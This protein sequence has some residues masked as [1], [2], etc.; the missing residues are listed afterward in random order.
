[1]QIK[2]A[3]LRERSTSGSWINFAV[4]AASA[5]TSGNSENSKALAQLTA[6]A[7]MAGYQVD[8]SALAFTENGRLKFY[9]SENLVDYL[10]RSWRPQWTHTITV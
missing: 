5:S 4:F 8:Q 6:K 1:M 7:K 3:H 2:F 9:G 10:S